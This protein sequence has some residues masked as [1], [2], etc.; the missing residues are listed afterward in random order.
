MSGL[1]SVKKLLLLA[2]GVVF[3]VS[4]LGGALGVAFGFGFLSSPLPVISLP[5]EAAFHVGTVSVP[6]TTIMLWIS[7]LVLLFLAWRTT[8][9]IKEVPSGLQNAF[10]SIYD[11]FRDMAENMG[12]QKAFKFLPIVMLIF[13]IVLASNWFGIIPGVGSFGR[14]ESINE[15]FHLHTSGAESE[16]EES[17]PTL[18]HEDVEALAI[19]EVLREERDARFVVFNGGGLALIPF[20]RSENSKAP[21]SSIVPVDEHSLE[22]LEH[23]I[24]EGG[25]SSLSADMLHKWEEIEGYIV[26]GVVQRSYFDSD[27][28]MYDCSGQ[29]TKITSCGTKRSAGLLIPFLRGSS[30]D[31]NLTLAI[32]LVAMGAVQFFGISS[33]GFLGYAGKFINFKE[34]PV[35][36]FVGVLELFAEVARIIS[37]TFRLFGNM[38]AG[39]ILLIVM[40]F[41]LPLIGILPFLGLELFVGVIQ[42][43]IFATLTL[44]FSVM[45]VQSHGS[46]PAH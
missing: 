24:V 15:W 17:Y 27:G 1:F 25:I 37:F 43:F 46:D 31:L 10:E 2:F 44:V 33:L 23:Q 32:A 39:E 22:E 42:A 45:A 6:N 8:R 26:Q 38:F 5:A 18:G 3:I 12:G 13:F 7:G 28:Q 19:I 30:T 29:K 4:V 20:G 35:G 11:F 21:L 36:F 9:N 34:G 40:G 41:L 16:F 14:V